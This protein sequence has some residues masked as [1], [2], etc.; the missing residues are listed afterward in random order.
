VKPIAYPSRAVGRYTFVET[1]ASGV[2]ICSRVFPAGFDTAPGAKAR[3][4]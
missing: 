4:L 2:R 3:L 1:L